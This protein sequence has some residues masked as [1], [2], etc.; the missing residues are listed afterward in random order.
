[1]T[2]DLDQ[3]LVPLDVIIFQHDHSAGQ[4]VGD[5][6]HFAGVHGPLTIGDAEYVQVGNRARWTIELSKTTRDL[7]T[8]EEIVERVTMHPGLIARTEQW[9]E[10]GE[11]LRRT[12]EHFLE[13]KASFE[14]IREAV[15]SRMQI[16]APIT[17]LAVNA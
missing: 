7:Q 5:F 3:G 10:E 8:G 1:M 11:R 2:H 13:D 15:A 12:D 14:A 16:E 4:Y 9:F 6:L 17:T